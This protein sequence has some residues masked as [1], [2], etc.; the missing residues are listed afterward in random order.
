M[1]KEA[2]SSTS[3]MLVCF[4][5]TKTAFNNKVKVTL[6]PVIYIPPCSFT[7]RFSCIFP[8]LGTV[9]IKIQAMPATAMF[10]CGCVPVRVQHTISDHRGTRI[11]KLL[12]LS[13]FP[14]LHCAV[15]G[16]SGLQVN[17]NSVILV[18][19]YVF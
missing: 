5:I 13:P 8:K 4:Q 16:R 19:P 11:F 10:K 1:L 3:L 18:N 2:A 6:V 9:H 12:L 17:V 14:K 15:D 7:F